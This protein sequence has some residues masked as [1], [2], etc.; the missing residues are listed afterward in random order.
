LG[1]GKDI[2]ET[3]AAKKEVAIMKLGVIADTH[4]DRITRELV[5]LMAGPFKDVDLVLHAGDIT[6]IDILR[7]FS[8][9]EMMAVCGNMDSPAVRKQLPPQRTFL[10]GKFRIGLIHGWGSPHGIEERIHRGFEGVD[11]IVYGH[12]HTPS[13]NKRES[14][15]FFNPG[16]FGSGFLSGKNSFG[17]LDIGDT[18]SG[19]IFYL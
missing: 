19:Q 15:L 7:A 8:G 16:T 3:V 13:V 11:C 10:A 6:E 18:I 9:K 2:I 1:N 17:V 4:L 12:T 5:D 14:I